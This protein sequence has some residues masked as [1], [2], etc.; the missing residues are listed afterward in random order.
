[1][2]KLQLLSINVRGIRNKLKREKIFL[3][4]REQMPD[5]TLLQET[6]STKTDENTWQTEWGGNIIFSHGKS[7]SAGTL[8]LFSNNVIPIIK[9]EISDKNGYYN[10]V[11]IKLDNN[12]LSES[13]SSLLRIG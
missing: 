8:I 10:V 5:V 9:N 13:I 4:I 3:W 6:H 12:N 7:N 11:K 1:M 2:G